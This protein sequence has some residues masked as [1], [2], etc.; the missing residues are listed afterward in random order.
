[1]S[2]APGFN[3]VFFTG[4]RVRDR[5]RLGAVDD[6]WKVSLVTLMNERLAGGGATG[7]GW[8]EFIDA[9][10]TVPRLDGRPALKDQAP[11][12]KPADWYVHTQGLKHTPNPTL[13]PPSPTPTP[14]P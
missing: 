6:G 4:V 7:A 12:E 2:G 10:R 3:E 5:Q 13:T 14:R 1:M 9:A 11:R 8:R